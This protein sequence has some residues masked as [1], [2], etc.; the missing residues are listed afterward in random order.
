MIGTRKIQK[1]MGRKECGIESNEV[2]TKQKFRWS[3]TAWSLLSKT[4]DDLPDYPN[5]IIPPLSIGGCF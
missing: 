4:A 5:P 1:Q 2:D 3:A